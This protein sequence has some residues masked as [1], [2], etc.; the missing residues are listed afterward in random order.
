MWGDCKLGTTSPFHLKGENVGHSAIFL[1]IRQFNSY[2]S[3][4]SYVN[5]IKKYSIINIGSNNLFQHKTDCF[6]GNRPKQLKAMSDV[7]PAPNYVR[8]VLQNEDLLW[9]LSDYLPARSLIAFRLTCKAFNKVAR[10]HHGPPGGGRMETSTRF[11]CERV[12]LVAWAVSIGMPTRRLCEGAAQ[13]ATIEVLQWLRAQDP[14]CFWSE[15][16]CSAAARG[17]HLA[18]LQWLRAQDPPCPWNLQQCVSG[19]AGEVRRWLEAQVG[20]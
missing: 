9:Y 10:R 11:F 19:S 17:G 6:A 14:P 7:P 3:H 13:S 18:V 1:G 15:D 4:Q 20:R 8:F 2:I 16:T 5:V 12:P